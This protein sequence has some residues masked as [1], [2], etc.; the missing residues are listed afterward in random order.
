MQG[1]ARVSK[2]NTEL[3]LEEKYECPLKYFMVKGSTFKGF[4]P[5]R[6]W[7]LQQWLHNIKVLIC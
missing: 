1:Y 5:S 2:E 7:R 3:E 6:R 4:K